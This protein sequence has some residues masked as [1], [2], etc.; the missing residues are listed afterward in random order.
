[1][2]FLCKLLFLLPVGL[3]VEKTACAQ[4]NNA[5][6]ST[7]KFKIISAG[8]QYRRS[9]WHNFFW[10]KNYRKEWGTPIKLPV[11]LLDSVKGGLIP[12]K[13]G[14]GHQT[15]SLH[16]ETKDGKNYSLRSVDKRLG[17]VL[18]EYFKGTFIERMVNDE[19]S[20]SNPYAAV[21]VP[22]MSQSAGI[23]HTNPEYVYLPEQEALGG[24][25]EKLGNK[26]YLFEQKPKGDWTNADNLGNFE[27]F[28]DTEEVMKKL[29]E[30]SE[31]RVDQAAF[32]KE[33]LFDMLIGD[34]DRHDNQ[35][36]WG[37]RKN[38][39]T[40][41]FEPV[42]EDRDQ[43]YF[44]HDGVL[45]NL[46]ISASGMHYMQSFKHRI[47]NTATLNYEERGLD[48]AFTNQLKLGDWQTAAKQLQQSLTNNLIEDAVKK[49]PPEIFSISGNKI[50]SDLQQRRDHLLEYATKYYLF[51]SRQ[52]EV[53]G[54]TNFSEFIQHQ[55][56]RNKR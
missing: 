6:D 39:A 12:I 47:Q 13:E 1:M 42:P 36:K 23:Y 41:I 9:G 53:V 10:G 21:T 49:L 40:N 29:H 56:R 34:W 16:L 50:I 15:T 52:V 55:Q 8:P 33:R 11:F 54:T 18:P 35:W 17:K 28:Y 5:V 19:V 30:E 3:F 25:D 37:V 20:M 43:V 7:S 26:V 48:R 31:N 44:K 46:A 27:K 32:V 2:K 45:I 51:I 22:V 4:K 14:G 38:G 24:F